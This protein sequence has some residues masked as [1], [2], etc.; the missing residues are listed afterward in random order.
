[1][2]F[3]VISCKPKELYAETANN[4]ITNQ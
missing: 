4:K 2:E 3:S 1:M